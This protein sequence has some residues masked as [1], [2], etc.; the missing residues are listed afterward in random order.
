M[1]LFHKKKHLFYLIK[2]NMRVEFSALMKNRVDLCENLLLIDQAS[3][4]LSKA[5]LIIVS[6]FEFGESLGNEVIFLGFLV[7]QI[8]KS[9]FDLLF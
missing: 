8:L 2:S 5:G 4:N 9:F 6:F 7:L 3:I 1:R